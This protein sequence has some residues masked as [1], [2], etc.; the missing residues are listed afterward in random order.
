MFDQF[1]QVRPAPQF[2]R[3]APETP[4]EP[5]VAP[6]LDAMADE[7]RQLKVD[8][9]VDAERTRPSL[10]A[11]L[12]LIVVAGATYIGQFIMQYGTDGFRVLTHTPPLNDPAK[13]II[14]AGAGLVVAAIAALLSLLAARRTQQSVQAFE[15]SYLD[16]GGTPTDA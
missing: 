13:L 9:A 7:L 10:N 2:E 16:L 8:A 3:A 11:F 6:D 15:R 12:A 14:A 4:V 5:P 1:E